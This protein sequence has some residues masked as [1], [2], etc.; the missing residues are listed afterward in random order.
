[1]KLIVGLGNPESDYSGTRHNM[2]FDVINKLA[3]EY[4]IDIEAEKDEIK[5]LDFLTKINKMGVKFMLSNVLEHKDKKND[6]LIK[7]IK[8][9]KFK[10]IEYTEKARKNRKEVIIVNYDKEDCND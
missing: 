5:L 3:E 6:L 7:W 9:N 2:G 1:M 10:V 4:K 8:D